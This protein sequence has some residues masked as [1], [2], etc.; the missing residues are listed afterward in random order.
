MRVI[1]GVGGGIAAYKACELTSRL[2]QNGHEVQ[3]LMS[4]AATRFVGPLTFSALSGRAVGVESEDEP[5]GPISHVRL[6]HWGDAM[7]IAPAPAEL[8]SRL[9]LGCAD[10]LLSLTYFGFLGPR[11]LAPAM[12]PEMWAH[13]AV[14]R[15]MD[16]LF[17]D[18][19]TTV[20][21]MR[22]RMASGAIGLGRM[23]EPSEIA[24][25][26]S[27]LL[28]SRDGEGIRVLITAGPTWEHFDPVRI[29]TNPS[30][31][32][33]GMELAV[34]ARDRGARVVV[35]HGPRVARPTDATDNI[36]F[37]AVTS[38]EEMAKAALERISEID[39]VIAAAAVSDFRPKHRL[40]E[41]GHKETVGLTWEMEP[42]PDVVRLLAA[43]RPEH[44]LVAGFA[45]ETEDPVASARVKLSQKGL[46]FIVAN[47]VKPG[48]GFGDAPYRG[49]IIAKDGTI[50][51]LPGNKAEAA[52]EILNTLFM[53]VQTQ[54]KG[55]GESPAEA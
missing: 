55:R 22:G 51:P 31:G 3:V 19:V 14:A 54:K 42:T 46:D 29:L 27:R 7:V 39:L 11:I 15:Q 49:Q 43:Q 18:G 20:G 45:A 1:L 26:L 48:E 35:I 21:P 17:Q 28:V 10:D 52:G 33:M 38:A 5:M 30:T 44:V 2:V 16:A 6:A 37:I 40:T 47:S 25:A 34:Q 4:R 12:E 32:K 23:A 50:R 13:P 41:K 9:A 24:R 53:A 8:I 36:R